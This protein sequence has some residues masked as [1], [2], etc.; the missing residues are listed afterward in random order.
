VRDAAIRPAGAPHDIPESDKPP[1]AHPIEVVAIVAQPALLRDV[2]SRTLEALLGLRVVAYGQDEDEIHCVLKL[3]PRVLL[4][5]DEV[6]GPNGES[7]IRRLRQVAPATRILVITSRSSEKAIASVL[8]AGACGLVEKGADLETLVRAIQAVAAGEVWANRSNAARAFELPTAL[9]STLPVPDSDGR[10]T[11]REWEIAERVGRGLRNKDIALRLNISQCTVKTH[12]NNIFRK[13]NL[14]GRV[15][16]GI[17]AQ[18][19][20]GPRT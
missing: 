19:R 8:R 14:D 11:K 3:K 15:S 18:S 7:T 20:I 12:L 6:L 5:D 17:L 1:A 13:L 16:L 4:L 2:L 10:L 9:R